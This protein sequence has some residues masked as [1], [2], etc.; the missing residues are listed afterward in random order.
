MDTFTIAYLIIVNIAGFVIMGIDKR[1]S[2]QRGSRIPEKL[3][4]LIAVIGGG[5][6]IYMGMWIFSHKTK[7]PLFL[8]GIPLIILI[9]LIIVMLAVNE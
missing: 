4:F 2:R 5:C 7:K 6:G 9:E 8:Y 3:L 1:R